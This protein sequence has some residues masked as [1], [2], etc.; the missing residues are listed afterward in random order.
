MVL[1]VWTWKMPRFPNQK[2]LSQIK[3]ENWLTRFK[4]TNGNASWNVLHKRPNMSSI[5]FLSTLASASPGRKFHIFTRNIDCDLI[6]DR[7]DFNLNRICLD[8]IG[9]GWNALDFVYAFF[10]FFTKGVLIG[11]KKLNRVYKTLKTLSHVGT[12]VLTTNDHFNS[13][14]TK[15]TI[16]RLDFFALNLPTHM[17]R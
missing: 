3:S 15:S 5:N 17:I 10:V 4:M 2:E 14:K 9:I 1:S 7:K 13:I 11:S 8:T 16:L 12:Y 6:N